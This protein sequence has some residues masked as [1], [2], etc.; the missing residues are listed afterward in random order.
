MK[1]KTNSELLQENI[2][3]VCQDVINYKK[4]KDDSKKWWTVE[5]VTKHL[6]SNSEWE[7]CFFFED[8]NVYA[9]RNKKSK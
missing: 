4:E 1:I 5:N 7:C 2:E 9:F 6:T 8:G 3:E